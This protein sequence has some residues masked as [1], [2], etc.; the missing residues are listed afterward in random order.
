L[1]ALRADHAQLIST[2]QTKFCHEPVTRGTAVHRHVRSDELNN[3]IIINPESLS[4][5]QEK[6]KAIW[7]LATSS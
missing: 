1:A 2:S 5:S 7:R 3:V 4:T 6:I